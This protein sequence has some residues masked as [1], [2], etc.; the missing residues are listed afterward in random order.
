[1]AQLPPTKSDE[2]KATTE[3]DFIDMLSVVCA[4]LC[5]RARTPESIAHCRDDCMSL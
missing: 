5:T 4:R 2:L 1:M 3:N